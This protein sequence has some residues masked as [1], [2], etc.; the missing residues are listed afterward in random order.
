MC[1]CEGRLDAV[2]DAALQLVFVLLEEGVAEVYRPRPDWGFKLL[3]DQ[4]VV[5]A[6]IAIGAVFAGSSPASTLSFAFSSLIASISEHTLAALVHHE[7]NEG[8]RV[9]EVG[10]GPSTSIFLGRGGRR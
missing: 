2:H 6:G 4:V 8:T 3:D 5:L 9:P 7:L 1:S 10:G